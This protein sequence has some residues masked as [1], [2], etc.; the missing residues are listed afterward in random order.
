[1]AANVREIKGR[2][3]AVGNIERITKTMQMIATARFQSLQRR[4]TEA[5]AYTAKLREVVS[6]LAAAVGEDVSHPLLNAPSPKTGKRAM[7]VITSN[8]GLCGGY[9][10]N[11]LRTAMKHLRDLRGDGTKVDVEVAGKKGLGYFRFNEVIVSEYHDQIEDTPA[12]ETVEAVARDYIQRFEAG[13][14]D[15]V[16]VVFMEFHSMSRQSPRVMQLLPMEP[17]KAE[18]GKAGPNAQ[19]EFSPDPAAL[20][21]SLLPQAVKVQLFQA[22]NEATVSEQI[23]RMIAMKSATDAAGKMKKRLKRDFNRARQTQITT[24]LSEIIGGAAALE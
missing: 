9:N 6:E 7:L 5:H 10:S 17:P 19:Y 21:S 3:K 2:I 11:V 16:D 8:R 20:L 14:L 12:Y 24:E 1:M 18:A 15:A 4:A 13:E 23:A 22:F